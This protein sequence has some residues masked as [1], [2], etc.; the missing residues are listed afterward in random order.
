MNDIPLSLNAS[1]LISSKDVLLKYIR[2]LSKT[3][4]RKL[5]N[6]VREGIL[7]EDTVLHINIQEGILTD[8]C[9]INI[10]NHIGPD[11]IYVPV[12][13]VIGAFRVAEQNMIELHAEKPILLKIVNLQHYSSAKFARSYRSDF[14]IKSLTAARF[15][16]SIWYTVFFS[17]MTLGTFAFHIWSQITNFSGMQEKLT[18]TAPTIL[19]VITS[20]LIGMLLYLNIYMI[21]FL[22][23][24]ENNFHNSL[25]VV[26]GDYSFFYVHFCE[27]N[28]FEMRIY[29]VIILQ[30]VLMLYTLLLAIF[31]HEK[32]LNIYPA[33]FC[34][35][36]NGFGLM[37][38]SRIA[39]FFRRCRRTRKGTAIAAR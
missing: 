35:L 16:M 12:P 28:R 1:A 37:L 30:L 26:Q 9:F 25:N 27:L 23:C 11:K 18:M 21:G 6:P 31:A 17:L 14:E 29:T 4:I 15:T 39:E 3:E 19:L 20:L 22:C 36:T 10:S 13:R 8:D 34:V 7:T 32:D 24:C 5:L 2:S 33:L 38:F